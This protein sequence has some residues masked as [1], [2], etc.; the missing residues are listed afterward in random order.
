M[1]QPPMTEA[2]KD[3]YAIDPGRFAAGWLAPQPE[4]VERV[5]ALI[6]AP[7]VP[8]HVEDWPEDERAFYRTGEW[9]SFTD[10]REKLDR[11]RRVK[12]ALRVLGALGLS[13]ETGV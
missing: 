7:D 4:I 8:Q 13:P 9:R 6:P 10:R 11:I 2:Q 5:A 1:N 3:A 12:V